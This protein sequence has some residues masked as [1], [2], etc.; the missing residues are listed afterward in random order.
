MSI[1]EFDLNLLKLIN[2][3]FYFPAADWIMKFI[4]SLGN[5][6][7][8]WILLA[9]TLLCFKKTR[10]M[11]AAISMAL[12]FSLIVGNILL[13]P[14]I[15]RVRPFNFDPTIIPLI[16]PPTD[17]SFPSGHTQS[18]F[19]AASALFFH[20]KKA[21]IPALMLALLIAFSRLYIMVHYPGDVLAG[22]IIGILLGYTAKKIS[23]MQ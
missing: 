11:G 13:K 23:S 10:R 5:G 15:S 6:G 12:I 22:I 1:T 18:S 3:I 21:G 7:F 17:F 4:S 16:S 19:A 8:I 2:E 20:N 9:V 14:I